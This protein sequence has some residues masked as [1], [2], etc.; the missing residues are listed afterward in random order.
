MYRI[1]SNVHAGGEIPAFIPMLSGILQGPVKG[2]PL[3]LIFVNDFP[4]ALEALKLLI[5][6]V[7]N[8]ATGLAQQIGLQKYLIIVWDWSEKWGLPSNLAENSYL[9]SR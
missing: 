3:V 7:V 5:T 1:V 4:N 9:T 2:R 6:D 8:I